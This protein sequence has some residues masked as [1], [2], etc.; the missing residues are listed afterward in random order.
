[1]A[2][3][4]QPDYRIDL[5]PYRIL[6]WPFLLPVALLLALY[7]KISPIPFKIYA[8]RVERVGQMAG[9][10]EEICCAID[11]GLYPK[12]FRVFIHRDHP[13]NSV[14]LE[15]QKRVLPI[16]NWFLPLF[17]ICHKLGGLGVSSMELH[18]ITGYDTEKNTQRTKQHLFFTQD[19]IDEAECQCKELGIDTNK[20]FVPV[21]ARDNSYLVHI[22][23]PTDMDNYRNVDIDTFIPAMEYLASSYKVIRMGSVV[24]QKLK[25]KHPQILDYSLSGKR[26]ELLDIYLSA[27]CSFFFSTGT[28]LDS[29]ASCC[30]R[31]P[32]L[33]VNFLPVS[34]VPLFK[35]GSLF[36]PKKYW[37]VKEERYLK[38][39]ELLDQ[40]GFMCTP[41][42]L[43][44]LGIV[45]HDN[46]HDE[47]LDATREMVA[48]LDG[49]WTDTAEDEKMQ[50][51][52]WSTFEKTGRLP[53][54]GRIGTD[55]L[56][57]HPNWLE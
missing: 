31:L 29:I 14:L 9:N 32:V 41:R 2:S 53:Y 36:I 34:A 16:N 52:F 3:Q 39:S 44:P 49:S 28:G 20:P 26:S 4:P 7:N 13:S 21:L 38:M 11:L 15:M 19:E 8:L 45:I 33:Y 40:I 10:Q 37:H 5:R 24:S 54:L 57:Q 42:E 48:R 35:P 18:R 51:Q 50:K 47:I 17:D 25:T 27:K 56:K 46:T 23:E 12:E 55:F 30:F 6:F 22:N 43:T 1:M